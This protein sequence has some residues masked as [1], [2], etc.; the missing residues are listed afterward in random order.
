LN[1]AGKF[2]A[3][4]S[5]ESSGL[6]SNG[7][8]HIETVHAAHVPSD[9]I[10][11]PDAHLLFH[12]EFKRSGVDLILSKDAQ[13]LVLHDYFKGEKRAALASPDGARLT[14]DIVNALSGHVEYAQADGSASVGKIIGHVTKLVGTA[15]AVRNGVSIILNNGDNVEKGDVVESGAD[16]RLGITFIDGTVFGLSSNA[17]MVLNEMVYDPNGSNN[18]SL[19]SMVSGTMTFVAGDTAKHGD[20][21]IDT[22]VA[23]MGI[24]GTAVLVQID[25]VAP[26]LAPGVVPDPGSLQALLPE[27]HVQVVVEPDGTV[28]S[29]IMYEKS[30]L[31]P[32]AV[33]DKAGVQ[34][35]ITNGI[36]SQSS[37]PLSP[38]LQKLI[39]EV[40]T[41][42]F[43]DNSNTKTTVVQND[44]IVPKD[45]TFGFH[46][47]DGTIVTAV[48]STA[49]NS[50]PD[51]NNS[52]ITSPIFFIPKVT[53]DQPVAKQGM[54]IHATGGGANSFAWQ[55]SSDNGKD[56]TTVSTDATYTPTEDDEGKL[57][58][59]VV[60]NA[61]QTLS[62]GVVQ[63][64]PDLVATL[65]HTTAQQDVAIHVTNVAD[66]GN[67]VTT[68][69]TYNWEVSDGHG[70]FTTVGTNA[71]F[72]PT[73]ADEGKTLQLV[74]TYA[75]AAGNESTTTNF[76]VVQP[77]AE[78]PTLTIASHTVSIAEE[79]GTALGI[80]VTAHDGDD[81]LSISISNVPNDATLT[82]LGADEK[83]HTLTPIGGV[84]TLTVDQLNG[85]T[86][87][88]GEQTGPV[89][90][91]VTATNTTTGE[92]ASVNDTISLTVN[93]IQENPIFSGA[94]TT[95]AS[96][97]GG[98]VTLG[99]TV[100]THD[101]DD[102]PISVTIT[103]LA[104]DLSTFNGG[105]YD[106]EAGTWSG[107]AAEF[108]ALS[109]KAGED[110]TQHLTIT[111]TTSGAEAG[112]TV[113][114]YTLTV[115]P[116]QENPVFG[117][118][119][120]TNA[121]EEGGKVTLGATVATH[122]ADDG[123]VSV[124]ITGLAHDLSAFNGGSYDSEAGTWSGTA[125][126]FNALSF[127]AG[128]DG[129]QHLTITA[130]TSGAEAGS[131]VESYTL[132]VDPIQENPVFS[133][134]VTTAANEQGG[135]VTLGASV[136]PHDADDG[137]ISV[138]ISGLAHDLTN[139]SGGTYNAGAGTWSGTAAEFKALSFKA[140]EDGTQN[141]TITATT[142]GAEAGS[143]VESYTLTVNPIQENPIFSGAVTT[144]ANE[145]GGVVTLGA[146]VAPH[147]ADDGAISV[148]ISGLAHD[149]S[150][151]NGGTYN[152]G[153]GTWSGTAAQF[154]ALSFK[155]GEDGAQHLTITAT[156]SG[157]EAGST[158]ENYTLTVNPVAEAASLAGTVTAVSGGSDSTIPLTIV[159]TPF[160]NDD[161]LSITITG[162]PSDASLNHGTRNSD[163]SYTLTLAQL[164]GLKYNSD[165][166]NSIL[167]V[168][169]TSSEGTSTTTS[170][171]D[172]A[173]S[174]D[175]SL[176][177]AA[178]DTFHLNGGTLTDHS[179]TVGGT[180]IGFGTVTASN[181]A[182]ANIIDS[183]L[184]EASSSHSLDLNANITGNGTLELTNNTSMEIAGSVASTL[185]TLFAVGG[186]STG[187][188]I[189]DSPGGFQSPITGFGGNDI[190]DLH[191]SKFAYLGTGPTLLNSSHTTATLVSGTSTE[192]IS[193]VSMTSTETVITVT[194][195]G[196][197]A[198]IKLEGNYNGHSFTFSSD[199]SGG[200]QFVD[201]L[202]ID[203]G[204]TLE[205]SG[206]SSDNVLFVNNVSIAG[207]L[208]L[209]D[210]AAFSGQISGF[211]GTS[212]TS[213]AID[214]KSITF[215]SETKWTYT[216]NSAGTGGAL[217]IYEGVT[218]V[219]TIEFTGN[220]TT[221]NFKVQ[222]DSNGGTLV[223]DP[224]TSSPAVHS[225]IM[226]DPG[227]AASSTIV[228]SAP[229]QTLSGIA[230]SDTFVFNFADVGHT[231]V[232]DFHPESDMLQ[233]KSPIFANALAA[234]NATYDDGLGNTIVAIDSHDSITLA[235]VLKVQLHASD[236]HII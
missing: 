227:P 188:L 58:Q 2:D 70:G 233:F 178:G 147:D 19:L 9:A 108:N 100:A 207:T 21:K 136:A 105:S 91:S 201:P 195:S 52:P 92:T 126:E 25:F 161:N 109:F 4:L 182:L 47:P 128:E 230:A 123:L 3:K 12:G 5:A 95:A 11:V 7:P 124:S 133:G 224:P 156:T 85:L 60:N 41:L 226:Q 219:D 27:L 185:K 181:G 211:A 229:N 51:Q 228:A 162:V 76:G 158:V 221:A 142:G 103:G 190:I 72:A 43:T 180:L 183:G 217:T 90:L 150:T 236:F 130:T 148:S 119:T 111:A 93:P 160:D 173:V 116:I 131:T 78:P 83:I 32:L 40:F 37:N 218:V 151:F 98:V 220:Y 199:G 50:S 189:L 164:S 8:V 16:S 205:L 144:A 36:V 30:T 54:A 57:L 146:S 152:A 214:L 225:V 31:T 143:T 48:F 99:A 45:G 77:V 112:S 138:S 159:A 87:H 154:N 102:G 118:S 39:D 61:S 89:T 69:I 101:A 28:G 170:T 145:Q 23:T 80:S 231:T 163:G 171:V 193:L 107:T 55:V 117:G 38:E 79:T 110:G 82:Y 174:V 115:N 127:K 22:P 175:S 88:A 169:V 68:G 65:D 166:D 208:V 200:T 20:M 165:E 81:V 67:T 96:E 186:G 6:H 42:R 191:N 198:T 210:A 172:I 75:D 18:S 197:T 134:A 13:E 114:S 14:G 204:A 10:I 113:E 73:E 46:L 187:E 29:L 176:T 122:D 125:A 209:D 167:H 235:G 44:S 74:V 155:A 62:L 168:V 104:H 106:S 17:R 222:S 121:N 179:I 26:K 64:T 71:S 135:V 24:R 141:L 84:Y 33:A 137:A 196:T 206:A 59:L 140:G 157:A 153:A 97:E 86:L 234:L 149:L 49:H 194:E 192:T 132:T 177:I 34:I 216:A 129:T 184:I 213:D 53:V 232:T 120:A 139:F 94:V 223:T 203:S 212:T 202:A 56:W 215:D 66:G 35:N 15:T 1:Y 63:E